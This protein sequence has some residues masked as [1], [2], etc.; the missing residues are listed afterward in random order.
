MSALDRPKLLFFED[1][2]TGVLPHLQIGYVSFFH[3]ML[4]AHFELV[5][6]SW[7]CDYGEEIDKARPDLVLFDGNFMSKET[8][9]E[10]R[11]RNVPQVVDVPRVGLIRQDAG[12]PEIL[13]VLERLEGFGVEAFFAIDSGFGQVHRSLADKLYYWIWAVDSN[14]AKDYGLSKD[15]LVSMTGHGYYMKGSYPWRRSIFAKV[16]FHFPCFLS[17]RPHRSTPETL[18]GQ[19]YAKV[20]NRSRLSLS[21]GGHRRIFVRKMLEIPACRSLL[22]TEETE[23]IRA[24]GFVDGEN[25]LFADSDNVVEKLDAALEDLD[26]LESMTSNGQNLVAANHAIE[27]RTQISDWLRLRK[28]SRVGASIVQRSPFEGL[29]LAQAD[30][31][32][33]VHLGAD[34]RVQQLNS[35]MNAAL[36]KVDFGEMERLLARYAFFNK[37]SVDLAL[38]QAL[39]SLDAR[40]YGRVV[41]ELSRTLSGDYISSQ[42]SNPV[43][44]A[45]LLF[46]MMRYGNP[47]RALEIARK[48]RPLDNPILRKAWLQLERFATEEESE[49]LE[50]RVS[51]PAIRGR[52]RKFEVEL[53]ALQDSDVITRL[54]GPVVDEESVIQSYAQND[55]ST[56]SSPQ[57]WA[58]HGAGD[59]G[60]KCFERYR[61]KLSFCCFFDNFPSD[62][63][64]CCGLDVARPE[65]FPLRPDMGIIA[66]NGLYRESVFQLL[67]LGYAIENIRVLDRASLELLVVDAD[68]LD[69]IG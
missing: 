14:H 69:C 26:R 13:H 65:D 57:R 42:C 24:A 29:S 16:A 34:C 68:T 67:T 58:I 11:I 40:R 66:T 4:A 44:F 9:R 2:Y 47:K 64:Y 8:A 56:A 50:W 60:R 35:R 30:S 38:V 36:R 7:D 1:D 27:N 37:E 12:A 55:T 62:D 5:I 22:V 52:A 31:H 45:C 53:P 21:C 15:L 17:N 23:T 3:R 59:F 54:F 32:T 25:C 61:A 6:V 49:P 46:S 39:V 20:L 51:S 48:I 41:S 18:V 63:G 19:E 33:T 43:A 28:E 10:L